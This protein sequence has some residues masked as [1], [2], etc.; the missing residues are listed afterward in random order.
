MTNNRRSYTIRHSALVAL[1]LSVEASA[2]EWTQFPGPNG[3]GVSA[4]RGVQVAWTEQDFRWRVALPGEGHS[5]PVLWGD[6]IFVSG[7]R[8]EGRERLLT[9][10]RKEDGKELWTKKYRLSGFRKHDDN[11][12]ASSTPVVDK[13]RV[14]AMFASTDHG[15]VKAWDHS[16]KE[17]WSV[18]LG[19][20]DGPFGPSIY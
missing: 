19:G 11:S 20:F 8:D 15:L 5:Q 9:C 12:F 14:F 1:L 17:L 2:Q 4:S 7:A 16:G 10:L 3:A 18:D 6:R 13:D